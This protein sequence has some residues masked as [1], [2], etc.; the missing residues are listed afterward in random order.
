[1]ASTLA[2]FQNSINLVVGNWQTYIYVYIYPG[3]L[4][5]VKNT[6]YVV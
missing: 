6:I 2:Y 1:M 5:I 4:I 3:K